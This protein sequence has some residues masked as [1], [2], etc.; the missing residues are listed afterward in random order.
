MKTVIKV[1]CHEGCNCAHKLSFE[2]EKEFNLPFVI[3]FKIG[4]LTKALQPLISHFHYADA[5]QIF[6]LS[7]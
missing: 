4:S 3:P 2:E 1:F 6:V 5:M 7:A